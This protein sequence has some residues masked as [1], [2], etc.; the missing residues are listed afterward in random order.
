MSSVV[1]CPEIARKNRNRRKKSREDPYV[2]LEVCQ[3]EC[4]LI[5]EDRNRVGCH[6]I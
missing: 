1:Y 6:R 3:Q 4:K 2:N 5:Q